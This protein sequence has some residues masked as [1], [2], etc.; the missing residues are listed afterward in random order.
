[1]LIPFLAPKLASPGLV[2]FDKAEIGS[3]TGAIGV[4]L[5]KLNTYKGFGGSQAGAEARSVFWP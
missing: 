2:T 1:M 3:S 4:K 5:L